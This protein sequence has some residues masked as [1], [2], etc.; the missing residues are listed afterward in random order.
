MM[1]STKWRKIDLSKAAPLI[2]LRY[3]KKRIT[4]PSLNVR[5]H[6]YINEKFASGEVFFE[7]I[8]EG[9]WMI[10][11]EIKAKENT[12][13]F[14]STKDK[15]DFYSVNFFSGSLNI[16]YQDQKDIY[17]AKNYVL[18]L[19]GKITHDI[20]VKANTVLKYNR[21]IF[22]QTFLN[23]LIGNDQ[24]ISLVTHECSGDVINRAA[25]KSELFLQNRLF[26]VL[27]NERN[28]NHY[29]A[30]LFSIVYGL[31]TSFIKNSSPQKKIA[32]ESSAKKNN[33]TMF[34]AA[35]ILEA[36][37]SDGFP[38]ISKIASDCN[39]SMSKLKRDFKKT[40]GI[41]PL[42]YFR[43]LQIAYSMDSFKVPDKTVK[44][45]AFDF[46]FK[47]SSSFSNWYKKLNG[48]ASPKF[49]ERGN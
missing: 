26:N 4:T 35:M 40:F 11:I 8:Q 3:F 6:F 9:F 49:Y 14:F 15:I 46:G 19:D 5:E 30:S 36:H 25:A 2:Y 23:V 17:W 21:L 27:R 41:T 37:L 7:K 22:T 1:V 48:M 16:G 13:Y 12:H 20:Y 42:Y 45:V 43:N 44:E 10:A 39:I 31:A 32:D 28:D 38:G 47:K 18:H 24:H 33:P 29:R 34:K